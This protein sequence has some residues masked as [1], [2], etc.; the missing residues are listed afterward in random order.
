MKKEITNEFK[1]VEQFEDVKYFNIFDFVFGNM[2]SLIGGFMM[3]VM[4]SDFLISLL[5]SLASIIEPL[6]VL[7]SLSMIVVFITT[8]WK[9]I[10]NYKY[11]KQSRNNDEMFK[12]KISVFKRNGLS[13]IITLTICTFAGKDIIMT[14][15]KNGIDDAFTT[16]GM[17]ALQEQGYTSVDYSE[18][19]KVIS[20]DITNTSNIS[21]IYG[22]W[23]E[24]RTGY[25]LIIYE[26]L[27]NSYSYDLIEEDVNSYILLVHTPEGDGKVNIEYD[28][29]I[30]YITVSYLDSETG[31]YIGHETYYRK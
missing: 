29:S 16:G 12:G 11:I 10:M 25:S 22:E 3:L 26:N 30:D 20:Q 15:I 5:P 18:V 21:L 17:K 23:T 19:E 1:N 6:L 27:Y 24:T 9:F 2:I 14:N 28:T 8:I 4:I 7:A 13:L 31:D